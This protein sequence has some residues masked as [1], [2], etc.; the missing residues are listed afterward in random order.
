MITL[1]SKRF[2]EVPLAKELNE[3]ISF[4]SN[5]EVLSID[6]KAKT[7]R[8]KRILPDPNKI[9]CGPKKKW[10]FEEMSYT[11]LIV[12]TGMRPRY[13]PGQSSGI[14]VYN[15]SDVERLQQLVA[16]KRVTVVGGSYLGVETAAN[17]VM[18][19]KKK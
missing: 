12:A 3:N 19:K 16:D 17:L 11:K 5:T 13:L 1:I 9:G 10:T 18:L 2:A 4:L 14:T 6:P 7:M 8:I 15:S